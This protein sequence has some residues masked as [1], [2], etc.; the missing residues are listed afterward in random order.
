MLKKHSIV[1][2]VLLVLFQVSK[3]QTVNFGVKAGINFASISAYNNP[4][5]SINRSKNFSNFLIGGVTK[6]EWTNLSL[7]T[8]LLLD[9]KG[10]KDIYIN[11]ETNTNRQK[12]ARLYYLEVPVILMYRAKTKIGNFF[13]GGGPYAAYGLWGSYTL[14]G[15]IFDSQVDGSSKVQFGN[16]ENSDYKRADYGVDFRT[17][18]RFLHGIGFELNY[19]Y[20]LRNIATPGIYDNANIKTRNKVFGI[21]VSYMFKNK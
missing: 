11:A 1:F 20:G 9:G 18:I 12:N 14:S 10:G 15:I 16:N 5:S 19:E 3:A 17:E 8:G 21:A 4:T 2:A 6:I 13:F 7:H